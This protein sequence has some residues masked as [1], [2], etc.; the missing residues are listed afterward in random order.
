[1]FYSDQ[2]DLRMSLEGNV[3]IENERDQ[4]RMFARNAILLNHAFGRSLNLNSRDRGHVTL[5]RTSDQKTTQIEAS[6]IQLSF[7]DL[8][9]LRITP[10]DQVSIKERPARS[11]DLVEIDSSTQSELDFF[12][13]IAITDVQIHSK[14]SQNRTHSLQMKAEKL[15]LLE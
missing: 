14:K 6:Q 8:Q 15:Q 1:V 3:E 12:D 7:P 5:L 13:G 9:T 10:I 4:L 11:T 2:H